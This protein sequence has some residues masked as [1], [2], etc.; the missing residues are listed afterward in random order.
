MI[1]RMYRAAVNATRDRIYIT[2]ASKRNL[3]DLD[4]AY[5]RKLRASSGP[6]VHKPKRII[7]SWIRA[8]NHQME[9]AM[10]IAKIEQPF[11][12]NSVAKRIIE[13]IFH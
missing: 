12:K 2:R 9:R 1:V 11:K 4:S 5:Y 13:A 7:K 6:S 10:W 8:Y 3:S